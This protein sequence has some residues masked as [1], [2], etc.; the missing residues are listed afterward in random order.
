MHI[1]IYFHADVSESH[2]ILVKTYWPQN[3]ILTKWPL[4]A[5]QHHL[6]RVPVPVPHCNA[7]YIITSVITLKILSYCAEN[8]VTDHPSTRSP[9]KPCKYV[10]KPY[11]LGYISAT[12][13]ICLCKKYASHCHFCGGL[14]KTHVRCNRVNNGCSRSSTVTDFG[15]NQKHIIC[16]MQ[17]R[18]TD[19][20]Q[21]WSYLAP[22]WR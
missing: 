8:P 19:Q 3:I 16:S 2:N 21:P 1:F 12:D 15:I 9:G 5:I 22:P 13:I 14:W 4:K 7:Y 17:L 18:I 20:Q 11:T 6:P 10:Y